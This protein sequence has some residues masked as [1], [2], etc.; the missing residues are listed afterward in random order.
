MAGP[1]QARFYSSTFVQTSLAS[2]ISSGATTFNVGTTTGASGTP[3]VVSV[4][5]NSASEELMLVTNVSGLTYTVTRG[6][7]GTSAQSHNNG[8][9]V[10]HVMYAQDLTDASAH[11]GAFDAVH[12]LSSGSLVV[13]TTDT[14]TLTNKSL[15]SPTLTTPNITTPTITGTT[16]AGTINSAALTS[17]A[18]VTAVDFFPTGLTGAGSNTRYVGGTFNAAPTSGT[19][20]TG[21]WVV[22]RAGLIWICTAAGTPGTWVSLVNTSATQTLSNKTI[23]A[24]VFTGSGS[25]TGN[26]A[27]GGYFQGLEFITAGLTGA[28]ASAA[29]VGGTTGGPPVSGTFAL[30]NFIVDQQGNIWVCISAG[31]PGSWAPVGG[32]QNIAAAPISTG[33]ASTASSGTTDTIDAVLGNYQFSAT[34]GRRYR[35]VAANMFGNGSVAADTFAVRVRD[36]ASASTP[37][38][39]STAVIDSG[40]TC[41]T[42]GSSGRSIITMEDT[43]VAG[44]SGTHTLAL[45]TQRISGTGVLTVVAP[46]GTGLRKLWAE[47]LGIG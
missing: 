47:D 25:G 44:V 4:D 19:F 5:Q 28:T 12:G 46:P 31:T 34:A 36:S 32:A 17:S 9:S 13:G 14:Q 23:A 30:G 27:L 22:D 18:L 16:T 10:V 20:S 26:I 42:T 21:D 6:I 45:F 33:T 1:G 7:G 37:T 15:T 35:V 3:F 8:A 39:A 38:T 29:F 40:W 41:N 24:G 43:F 2:G 11:I